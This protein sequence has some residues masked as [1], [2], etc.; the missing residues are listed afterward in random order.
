M[1]DNTFLSGY[2][3]WTTD[4]GEMYLD[5]PIML[6]S[7]ENFNAEYKAGKAF[8]VECFA[9]R[10]DGSEEKC[11]CG[12][13]DPSGSIKETADGMYYCEAAGVYKVLL[14]KELSLHF[15]DCYRIF[16]EPVLLAV[17]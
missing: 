11:L 3:G 10:R 12:I 1:C 2:D 9:I 15:G 14:V 6:K 16:S 8:K 7:S 4:H 13:F 17:K 5:Y